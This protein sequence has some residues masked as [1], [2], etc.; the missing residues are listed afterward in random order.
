VFSKGASTTS[1]HPFFEFFWKLSFPLFF[2][3][4]YGC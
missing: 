1:F 2:R 4:F 3:L